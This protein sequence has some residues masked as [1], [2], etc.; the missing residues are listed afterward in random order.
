M[1]FIFIRY[2]FF[3]DELPVQLMLP[4][5]IQEAKNRQQLSSLAL[6]GQ[7]MC[8]NEI[9]F[10]RSFYSFKHVL[11]SMTQMIFNIEFWRYPMASSRSSPTLDISPNDE[12]TKRTLNTSIPSSAANSQSSSLCS[13]SSGN[14]LYK[15]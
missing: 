8:W 1:Y 13:F 4:K 3:S 12:T 7:G 14:I 10:F 9:A 11:F 5:A 15:R 6:L 2:Q